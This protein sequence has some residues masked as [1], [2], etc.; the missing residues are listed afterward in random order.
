M[1]GHVLGEAALGIGGNIRKGRCEQLS[2]ARIK[3]W[4]GDVTKARSLLELRRLLSRLQLALFG[5]DPLVN[6]LIG[7]QSNKGLSTHAGRNM[8]LQAGAPSPD[9]L[10]LGSYLPVDLRY[11][12]RKGDTLC[13]NND[14]IEVAAMGRIDY[15]ASKDILADVGPVKDCNIRVGC[16]PCPVA[17]GDGDISREEKLDL[18]GVEAAKRCASDDEGWRVGEQ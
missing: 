8:P 9:F 6:R 3:G 5:G 16:A 13:T 10:V 12:R 4:Q 17:E 15:I 2:E 11:A 18:R 14:A 7:R 1:G